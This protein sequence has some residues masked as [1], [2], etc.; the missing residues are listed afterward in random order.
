MLL[1]VTVAS[2]TAGAKDDSGNRPG[3]LSAAPPE[4]VAPADPATAVNPDRRSETNDSQPG[5]KNDSKTPRST[6]KSDPVDVADLTRREPRRQTRSTGRMPE[7]GSGEFVTAAGSTD[8][9]GLGLLVTYQVE[10]EREVP[11][12]AGAA[13]STVDRTLRDPRGWTASGAHAL[14]RVDA[15][16]D[17]RVLLATPETTDALCAPLDTGGRLSCRN[18][19]LVVLN[20]WRWLN[21]ADP[22]AG[23]LRS[24]R[25]YLVNHEMGHALGNPHE[26]CPEPGTLAPVMMQ[27]TKGVGECV[28][29][30]WPAPT[31]D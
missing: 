15:G 21:G 4:T 8:T 22:Y 11:V 16:G 27:Q 9:V 6:P 17:V 19:D 23:D 18:G 24:Y 29:N 1:V 10:V 26:D 7:T 31:G 3:T 5:G 20:A 13:A 30:P 25:R 14:A 12:E 28:T 2:V